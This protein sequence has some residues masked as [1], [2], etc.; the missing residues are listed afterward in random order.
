M[1][2]HQLALIKRELFEHRSIWVTPAAIASVMTLM[3]LTMQV[4]ASGSREIVDIA[5]MG[6]SNAGDVPRRAALTAYFV[7]ISTLFVLAMWIMVI[8]YCLDCLYA[9]RK[10]KSILFWR[11]L[12]ITDAETVISKLATAMLLIPLV[13]FIG[14]AVTHLINLAL[15]SAW[16]GI[17]GGDPGH[18]IW[19]AA[20]ILDNWLAMFIVLLAI[21]LWLSPFIGW[22]LFVSAYAKRMP[23]LLSFMP[24]F[25]LP[26]L[27]KT[28]FKSSVL[29]DVLFLRT[30]RIPIFSDMDMSEFF[31][32]DNIQESAAQAASLMAHLDVVKFLTS[33][34]LWAGLL[35]CG[36][37][38]TAAIYVRRYRDE[39]Y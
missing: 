15:S 2:G 5:I 12:P 11:S 34:S 30:P 13:T 18:L 24:I 33:P 36:L 39:S 6:A 27:E 8:F 32:E 1:I 20:P 35:A 25:I 17:E 23:L 16:I 29:I 38:T 19:G 37:F 31:D 22:F 3:M 28:I 4:F 9:E 14:I 7:G 26:L 10:D 21:P